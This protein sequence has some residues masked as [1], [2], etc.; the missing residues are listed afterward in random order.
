M[1]LNYSKCKVIAF[2]RR[3]NI[4][5]SDYFIENVKPGRV[6]VVKDLFKKLDCELKLTFHIEDILSK[7]FLYIFQSSLPIGEGKLA[8]VIFNMDVVS[9]FK[10]I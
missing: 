9:L 2:T 1:K 10:C 4:C 5:I 3:K 8:A 6:M 7:F